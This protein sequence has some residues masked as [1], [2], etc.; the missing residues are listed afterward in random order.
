MREKRLNHHRKN[1]HISTT[2]RSRAGPHTFWLRKNLFKI[3]SWRAHLQTKKLSSDRWQF[4]EKESNTKRSDFQL[5]GYIGTVLGALFLVGGVFAYS[6]SETHCNVIIP[7]FCTTE[8]PYREYAAGLLV[9]GVVLLVV[10]LAFLWRAEQEKPT[11][12]AILQVPK[13]PEA[14]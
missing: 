6:C 5:I 14:I 7:T 9:A 1:M 8:Y 4:R 3:N 11:Q 13:P 2:L 12:K 10:G